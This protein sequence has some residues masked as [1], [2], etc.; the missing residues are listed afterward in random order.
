MTIEKFLSLTG[1][2]SVGAS[3]AAFDLAT[4]VAGAAILIAGIAVFAMMRA[5]KSARREADETLETIGALKTEMRSL[6]E[7]L[8]SALADRD[9]ALA[10]AREEHADA[11]ASH[12]GGHEDDD[13][14]HHKKKHSGRGDDRRMHAGRE[15]DEDRRERRVGFK[16]F[17]SRTRDDDA[18]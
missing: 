9:A 18:D 16:L 6:R 8:E 1:G 4:G 11:C 3:L 7:K 15:R 13:V 12:A 14:H 17:R 5:S 2:E 10:A